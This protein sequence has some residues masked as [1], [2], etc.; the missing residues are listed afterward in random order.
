MIRV[1]LA[2]DQ[3]MVRAGFRMNHR[4]GR[5]H[6][7]VAEAGNGLEADALT[8][9]LRPDLVLT[10]IRMPV[11]DGL[12]ATRRIVERSHSNTRVVILTTF[13][14]DQYVFEALRCGASGFL[15]KNAPPEELV[16]AVRVVARG[17]GLISASVTR[18]MIEQFSRRQ[19]PAGSAEQLQRLTNRERGVLR[20][21]AAG[22][23]D[24]EVALSCTWARGR[25]DTR[26]QRAEQAGP[27]GPGP[28]SRVRLREWGW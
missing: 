20:Q 13:E 15:L 9:R 1:L 3:A 17:D 27:A 25:Q 2:D 8:E 22:K 19:V 26:G 18:R 7:G 5:R 11:L 14:R 16:H 24:A 23:S 12:E 21:L 6:R 10:D 4:G 28:S